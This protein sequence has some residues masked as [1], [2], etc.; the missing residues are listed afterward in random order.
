MQGHTDIFIQICRWYNIYLIFYWCRSQ[1]W[2]GSCV[3][4]AV[5]Q[6]RSCSPNLIP[7][8]GISICLGFGPKTQI[9]KKKF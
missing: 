8:L 1:M 9:N 6:G 3:A 4:V 7:N 5:V 2:L